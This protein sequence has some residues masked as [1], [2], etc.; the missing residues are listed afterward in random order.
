MVIAQE[1]TQS[2]AALNWLRL[3]ADFRI[4]GEQ[5][6]VTLALVIALGVIHIHNL[7]THHITVSGIY[8]F[9]ALLFRLQ[10]KHA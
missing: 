4:T 10:T 5:Q 7:N 1:P 3:A 6:D 9:V 8:L 2:L